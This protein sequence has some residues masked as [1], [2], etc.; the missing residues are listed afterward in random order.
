MR[1]KSISDYGTHP[2]HWV[3]LWMP[4]LALAL[5]LGPLFAIEWLEKKKRHYMGPSKEW[6]PWFAWHPATFEFT[7][8]TAWLEW[9]ERRRLHDEW[10][11]YRAPT[12]SSAYRATET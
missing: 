10:T 3:W 5:L 7:D 12:I 1:W 11:D 8:T 9:I 2:L 4:L 6:R